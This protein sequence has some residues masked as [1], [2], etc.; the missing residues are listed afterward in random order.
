MNLLS[1]G[2]AFGILVAIYQKGY[3]AGLFGIS[4]TGPVESF[5]PVM[6]PVVKMPELPPALLE[7]PPEAVSTAPLPAGASG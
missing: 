3:G 4:R 5:I 6:L 7:S 2:A 1:I